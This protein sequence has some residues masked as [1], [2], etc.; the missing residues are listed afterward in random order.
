M[1]WIAFGGFIVFGVPGMTMLA[2]QSKRAREILFGIMVFSIVKTQSINIMSMEH[3]R[4]ADRG[5]EITLT[6]LIAIALA[7]ALIAKKQDQIKWIPLN[8]FPMAAFFVVA[9][10]SALDTPKMILSIFALW[11][12]PRV[13]IIFWATYNIIKIDR[14]LKGMFWGIVATGIYEA[15]VCLSQK[16]IQGFYRVHGT[17]DHS[18]TIPIYFFQLI[19]TL[20]AWTLHGKDVDKKASFLAFGSMG[21]MCVAILTTMS[22]AGMA[23]MGASVIAVMFRMVPQN[24]N[25]RKV[26]ISFLFFMVLVAGGIKAAD[27]I[28]KRFQTAPKESAMARDEFNVA[29]AKMAKD[30]TFGV[31]INSYSHVLTYTSKYNSHIKVMANEKHAGVCHHIYN[32]TAAETGYIGLT[33]YCTVITIFIIKLSIYLLGKLSL[34]RAIVNGLFV[35]FGCVHLV[36]TLEW[37]FR[38]TPVCYLFFMLSGAGSALCDCIKADKKEEKRQKAI[39]RRERAIAAAAATQQQQSA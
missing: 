27:S 5:F 38:I 2:M 8:T 10:L 17:F 19:P 34:E 25:F 14:P 36:G 22:R 4:G 28:I 39:R 35:G 18:N 23:L 33:V 15:Y 9:T 7:G 37:A 1:K 30:K 16:Y 13:Y 12:M 24:L 6:E 20:L 29:A 3:Y 11:K 21:G 31:G 32:L 26:G